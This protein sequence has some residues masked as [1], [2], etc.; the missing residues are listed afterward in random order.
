MFTDQHLPYD[1]TER[2]IRADRRPLPR[3]SEIRL[4][5][6]RILSAREARG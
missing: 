6:K 1:K 5:V 3:A 4:R 2:L